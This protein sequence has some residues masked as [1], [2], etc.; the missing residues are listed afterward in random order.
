MRLNV[1]R[2]GYGVMPINDA[3]GSP[4]ESN[5]NKVFL[6]AYRYVVREREETRRREF[7]Q[8]QEDE[9]KRIRDEVEQKRKEVER[10][11]AEEDQRRANLIKQS[12]GWH[13]SNRIRQLV[14]HVQSSSTIDQSS[15]KFNDWRNWAMAVAD[16]I[17]P[18]ARLV[19]Q[20]AEKFDA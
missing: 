4:I 2:P 10:L 8:Q 7:I 6:H 13:Q 12:D 19:N 5:L 16:S 1:E 17:D 14:H 11:K 18:T 15:A 20:F 9:K 3:E